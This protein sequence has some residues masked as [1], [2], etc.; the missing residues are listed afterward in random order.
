MKGWPRLGLAGALLLPATVLANTAI[1]GTLIWF[2]GMMTVAPWQWVSACMVMCIAVEG[3]IYRYLQLF[4]KPFLVS[5]VLNLLSLLLGIPL[6]LV[7]VID[8]SWFLLPTLLSALSEGFLARHLPRLFKAQAAR[9]I[10]RGEMYGRVLLA[11]LVSNFIMFGYLFVAF[12]KAQW[13]SS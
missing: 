7:G 9:E 2:G 6:A 5:G 8:P 12:F 4:S 10:G 13:P 11:N 3:A 1:P